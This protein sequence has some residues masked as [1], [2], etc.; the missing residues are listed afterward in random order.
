MNI[1]ELGRNLRT[2][3]E[4][5]GLSV[6]DVVQRTRISKQNILAMEAGNTV[7]LPHPVYAKGFVRNYAKLLGLDPELYAEAMGREFQVEDNVGHAHEDDGSPSCPVRTGG[8]GGRGKTLAVVVVVLAVAVVVAVFFFSGFGK[9]APQE[10][11]VAVPAPQA[12]PAEPPPAAPDAVSEAP[13]TESDSASE[14]A[15]E[16]APAPEAPAEASPSAAG[17]TVGQAAPETAGQAAPAVAAAVEPAQPPAA[18]P[19]EDQAVAGDARKRLLV[20]AGESCWVLALVDGGEA[21][22]GVTVDVMLRPGDTKLLRF[23]KSLTLK[24]GNAG[25]VTLSL[26]GEPYAFEAHSGQVKTLTF[27]GD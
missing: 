3:R 24:L 17:E 20:T 4:G 6:E 1:E 25:G 8:S 9:K 16:P 7:G 26:N 18:A 22:D 19:A 15:A 5:K 14:P 23:A 13:A 21:G 11:S 12:A 27:S 10:P 2:A